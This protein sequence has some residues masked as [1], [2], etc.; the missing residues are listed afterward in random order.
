MFGVTLTANFQHQSQLIDIDNITPWDQSN[1]VQITNKLKSMDF[2][3]T[4][5][6]YVHVF[7][8]YHKNW[9]PHDS[10]FKTVPVVNKQKFRW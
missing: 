10:Y 8:S 6:K 1:N 7:H 9:Y 4:S 2:F 5:Q 3:S